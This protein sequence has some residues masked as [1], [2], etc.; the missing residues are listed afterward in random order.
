MY[1]KT[2]F[3][4]YRNRGTPDIT[5]YLDRAKEQTDLTTGEVCTFGCLNGLKVEVY[6]GGYSI[7]GSLSKFHYGN[8]IYPLDAR[9]TAEAVA[10]LSDLLHLDM[11]EAQV[12]CLEFG[13]VFLM[14]KPPSV[15]LEKLGVMPRLLRFQVDKGALYYQPKGKKKP[16]TF[17]FYDKIAEERAKGFSI[18]SGLEN[19]NL[20]KYELRLKGKLAQQIGVPE[21][22]ASTLSDRDFYY[23]LVMQWQEYYFSI[24]KLNRIKQDYMNEIKTDKDAFEM[25][26]A[27]RI[28]DPKEIADY[29]E[30]LKRAK[31][32]KDRK[33]YTR[34]KQRL[35]KIANKANFV[36]TDE[37][38]R[39]LDDAVKNAGCYF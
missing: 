4:Y 35:E 11:R 5:N 9:E 12:T 28:N 38:I 15:Y 25:F 24:Q 19:A 33:Y 29:I 37:D 3:F 8:N 6:A 1:D 13:S 36:E 22:K 17:C 23:R 30:E 31:V 32:F 16:K 20:L 10:K 27:Q 39:E 34:L 18:P 14:S 2:A 26:F 21:V 7:T